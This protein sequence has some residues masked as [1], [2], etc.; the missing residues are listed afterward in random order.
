MSKCIVRGD[1]DLRF[2]SIKES[3]K[4]SEDEI[5]LDLSKR[6]NWC[7]DADSLGEIDC[8]RVN[9]AVHGLGWAVS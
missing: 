9:V 1:D 4:L 8:F 5:R 3:P 7:N 2:T 6:C